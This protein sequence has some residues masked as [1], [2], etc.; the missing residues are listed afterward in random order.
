MISAKQVVSWFERL[1]VQFPFTISCY[2]LGL[3]W[4]SVCW[5]ALARETA[6]PMVLSVLHRDWVSASL[7]HEQ[8][9]TRNAQPAAMAAGF[10]HFCL[11]RLLTSLRHEQD[12]A[13][14]AQP[15]AM[16]TGFSHFSLH[17][18][19]TSLENTSTETS[20]CRGVSTPH[21]HQWQHLE[22]RDYL[23]FS[24]FWSIDMPNGTT[25]WRRQR[26]DLF[27]KAASTFVVSDKVDV[28][29]FVYR[30]QLK[31]GRVFSFLLLPFKFRSNSS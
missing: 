14:N 19:L 7:R 27:G 3:I 11:R 23:N 28:F 30:S 1:A 22:S 6:T 16:A 9:V 26:A 13:W 5:A 31:A 17:R 15:A 29:A 21:K 12:I 10:S 2:V 4:R 20:S 18:L 25:L 8:D 24:A